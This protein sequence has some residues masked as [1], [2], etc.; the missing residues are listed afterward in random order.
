MAVTVEQFIERLT[1]SGLMSAA[2]VSTFRDSLPP[3]KQPED[4]ETLARELVR[5]NK[6]TKYQAQAVY[7]G[8]VKGLVFGEYV[9]L[10]KLGEGGMGVVLKAQHR[11]MKRLVAI[12]VLSSAAMKQAGAVER[13][14]REVEAAAKLEHSNIVAAYD[15]SEHQGM[16]YLAMQYVDGK[17]LASIVK[18]HGPLEIRQAVEYVLQAARGLQYAHEQGIVHRDIKPG[19]LLLDKKGTVKILDMGLARIAGAEAALGGPERLTATGQVMGTCDY[20][21]PEQAMDTHAADHRTDIYALGCTL[22]RLLT[23]HPPY[24]GETLMK[25]LWEHQQ[26]PIPSLCQA[27][28]EVPAELDACFQRMMAKE[29]ADRQQSMAEVV[30]ELEAVLAVL[31]GHSVTAA[32][33]GDESPNEVV[34]RT[35]AFLQEATPRGTLTKQ[36]KST[37]DERTQPHISPQHGTG[38]NIL[39]KVKRAFGAARR[40]P[41]LLLGIGGGLVVLLLLGIVLTLTLRQGTL[42][43]EIDEQLGKDVQVAVSQGGE[44]VQV[45]DAKSGWTLSLG[46]GQYDLAVQGGDD[47]FQ[48]DCQSITVTHGGQV[49][50]KLTLNPAPLAVAPFDAKQARKFQERWARQLGV[51]VEMTNSIGMKL[52]LIPPGEFVMGSP[53]ELIEEE[54]KARGDDQWHKERLPGEGPQHRVRVTKP[55]CLGTYLVTQGEYQR[56]MGVNP[57]E[58]SATGRSKDRVAGQDTKR[59]PV[60]CV[61]WDDA[62]E[63]CRKLSEMPEE[64]AAGRSYRLPS[65]AQWEYACRA[66][67]QE[68]WHFGNDEARLGE[69]G[70]FNGNAGGQTH[71]VGLLKANPLG[72]YDIY[73]NVWQWCADLYYD[74]YYAVSPMDDPCGADSGSDRVYR[75][76]C[77]SHP[78]RYCRSAFRYYEPGY[79]TYLG[80]RVS[81][82]LADKP[83]R[84][85]AELK[86][87]IPDLKSQISNPE[88]PSPPPA[89]APFDAQKAKEHQEGWSKHL[90]VPV[91]ITNSIGMKLVLI[92]PGEFMMGSPKELIEEELKAHGDDQSYKERLLAEGPQHRV[93]ITEPFCL[94]TYLVTQGEYQRVMGVNP[95]EFS[96]TGKSKDKVAGQDTKR[97]P[98]EMVSWDDALEFCRKLS[99]MPEE[100]AAGRSYRLPSEA[101]WEY[102]CRAGSTSRYSFSSVRSEIPKEFEEN[103]L[104]DYGWF[105]GNSRGMPHAVGGKRPSAW[106]LYDMHGNVSEWCQDRYGK[107]YYAKSPTNDP[108]GPLGGSGRVGC[109]GGW[110]DPAG[111]CR[112]ASRTGRT[113]GYP[114]NGLGFRVS[115]VLPD[116]A[117]ERAKPPVELKSKIPDLKS[118]IPN[119]QSPSPP[120]AVAPFNAKHARKYQERWEDL[121]DGKTLDGWKVVEDGGEFLKHGK[122]AVADGQ[123]VLERGDPATGI[124][125]T[126]DIPRVDYEISLEAMRKG[127][128]CTMCEVIFPVKA[129]ECKLAVGGHDNADVC[130]E[131]VDGS[132]TKI[133]HKMS[134]E[135]DRWYRIRLRVTDAAMEAWVDDEE[136]LDFNPAGHVVALNPVA[137]AMK[138]FGLRTW[139]T[140]VAIR[141]LRLR[142]LKAVAAEPQAGAW[143]V[144]KGWPFDAAW[145]CRSAHRNHV[146]AGSRGIILGFRASLVLPPREVRLQ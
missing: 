51:P 124:A 130:F 90:A 143:K 11:R 68:K 25:I 73:G 18:E 64:K 105:N 1:Q 61:S 63:F 31:S 120:P 117:V 111:S 70:W 55:F 78:A 29:P 65:E 74:K 15:A 83:G 127:G 92:P 125:W 141:N 100:K 57:S 112:S 98:V 80:F 37:A 44:K 135:D 40:R 69:Y 42:V 16:H 79:H 36:K 77:W 88:S 14:H 2:E 6:L 39:S 109:G 142:Q 95:S 123:L 32:A 85:P 5:A 8:K 4:A 103:A 82:V 28:P 107:D 84:P 121:F 126:R 33:A 38:S 30:A 34:A 140:G 45:A 67:S 75:G 89:V 20:M 66:G 9:V 52:V 138:P 91:E 119:P 102:A 106:G 46:A 12:K 113:P 60:E 54:L 101:Q 116:T 21:S 139:K 114:I 50:A 41:L 13:F 96:A 110:Y 43:V 97:F 94:G 72:L 144:Y 131:L 145:D 104:S 132:H 108:S 128:T 7:G 23:G 146:E 48:L 22:C 35:L 93:R 129:T 99:E 87:Q 47:Q 10:D 19:N 56:V 17:D 118:Q 122:V 133:M 49:K 24:Q 59:F 3:D 27:R 53:K 71:R 58:F 62:V 86:S 136:V 137:A 81:L 76:G 115:L 134:F 26:A